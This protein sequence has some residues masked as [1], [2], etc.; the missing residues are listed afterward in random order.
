MG[1]TST[2][3]YRVHVEVPGYYCTPMAWERHYGAPTDA[4]LAK[5]VAVSNAATDPGG[6]NSHLGVYHK[7]VKADVYLNIQNPT[8]A[9]ATWRKA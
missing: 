6:V 2:P 8:H 1:H 7:I 4:N 5:F 3:K 9:L